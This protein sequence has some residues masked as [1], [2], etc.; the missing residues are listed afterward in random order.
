MIEDQSVIA[1]VREAVGTNSTQK[2][3]VIINPVDRDVT[4]ELG[5]ELRVTATVVYS[6]GIHDNKHQLNAEVDLSRPI[7]V[8]GGEL[9][10]LKLSDK[11]SQK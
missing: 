9:V 11:K 8:M 10:V 3:A 2:Y 4:L 1:F 5:E 6:F 7:D